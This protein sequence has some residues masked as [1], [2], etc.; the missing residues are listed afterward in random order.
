MGPVSL[1]FTREL[2]TINRRFVR[3]R[4]V[5]TG[6]R[7]RAKPMGCLPGSR[8]EKINT[9]RWIDIEH[10]AMFDVNSFL[11]CSGN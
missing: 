2:R 7:Q 9:A 8:M 11:V 4:A 1:V 5:D 6:P 3:K 10:I